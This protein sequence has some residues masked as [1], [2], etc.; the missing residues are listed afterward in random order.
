MTRT[1]AAK[2]ARA[3]KL[4]KQPPL[5]ERFW[6]KVEINGDDDCWPW[7][8]ATRRKDEGY[9]AFWLN[10][11]H[12][13]S[14]RVAWILER[15]EIPH[16]LVVCHSCDNP[17]CCNPD[18]LFLGSPLENNKDKV[19]KNRQSKGE[20]HGSSKL[21]TDQVIEIK[22]LKP[23]TLKSGNRKLMDSLANKF[24]VKAGTIYDVWTRT[25]NHLNEV[26]SG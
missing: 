20:S 25:W 6:S 17:S 19:N 1:E 21:T 10:R 4:A 18:H 23:K 14:N 11:R 8:A 16:G 2:I 13:P 24:N 5:E 22:S 15:G 9:G 12:Q 26:K 3:A 7:T